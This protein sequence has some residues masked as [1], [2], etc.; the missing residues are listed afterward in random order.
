MKKV[1]VW[2]NAFVCLLAVLVT[3]AL[4]QHFCAKQISAQST[5]STRILIPFYPGSDSTNS[6]FLLVENTSQDPY[7]TTPS[8]NATCN[9]DFY[10][11]GTHYGPY[12]LDDNLPGQVSDWSKTAITGLGFTYLPNSSQMAYI[13]LTCNFPYAHAQVQILNSSTGVSTVIPGYVIPPNRSFSTG[14]EQ[15]LQ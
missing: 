14:P 7:G 6:T 5:T 3:F 8:T 1:F 11:G 15:L 9:A 4:Y 12:E 13:F 10:Y 2:R